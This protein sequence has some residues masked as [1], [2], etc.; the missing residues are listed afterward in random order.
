MAVCLLKKLV[1][2]TASIKDTDK[3]VILE[4]V[5]NHICELNDMASLKLLS[6][7]VKEIAVYYILYIL[8]VVFL[9]IL[10]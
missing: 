3:K 8:H 6:T 2:S 7:I 1:F 9:L 4:N 5:I 10:A